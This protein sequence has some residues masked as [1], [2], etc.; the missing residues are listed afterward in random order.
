MVKS[1]IWYW[2]ILWLPPKYLWIAKRKS[3]HY[4]V[5]NSHMTCINTIHIFLCKVSWQM[6][7][8]FESQASHQGVQNCHQCVKGGIG[9]RC[10]VLRKDQK[11]YIKTGSKRN[12]HVFLHRPSVTDFIPPLSQTAIEPKG[13]ETFT[14]FPKIYPHFP[15]RSQASSADILD[16]PAILPPPRSP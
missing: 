15:L 9:G 2:G 6:A 7:C 1:L 4:I 14:T 3:R 12:S 16:T 5:R 11:P 13:T 10:P 8:A